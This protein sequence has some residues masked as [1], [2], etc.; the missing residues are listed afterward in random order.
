[1][2]RKSR[3]KAERR[4]MNP[5]LPPA[6]E[7]QRIV[8]AVVRSV[9]GIVLN[10]HDRQCLLYCTVGKV[11]LD[12]YISSEYSLQVGHIQFGVDDS[13]IPDHMCGTGL[14][15]PGSYHTWLARQHHGGRIEM[16]DFSWGFF[17]RWAANVGLAWARTDA[18]SYIWDWADEIGERP[19]RYDVR[20]AS[21]FDLRRQI[22]IP[23]MQA[24]EFQVQVR[25]AC[26]TASAIYLNPNLILFTGSGMVPLEDP[27]AP[28]QDEVSILQ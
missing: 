21:S 10:N 24:P 4:L 14:E 15:M 9:R 23:A 22:A 16:I 6:E 3:E 1:M 25:H 28:M 20:Y 12:R 19:K 13:D 26:E 8:H 7:R 5:D 17:P 27:W 18:P 11:L 2:G